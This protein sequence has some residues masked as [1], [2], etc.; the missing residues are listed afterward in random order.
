MLGKSGIKTYI[1]QRI[2]K[3]NGKGWSLSVEGADS[4]GKGA[5][6]IRGVKTILTMSS[7]YGICTDRHF[8]IGDMPPSARGC[9]PKGGG[10]TGAKCRSD[11]I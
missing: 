7:L 6:E 4:I 10:V 1:H 3:G 9:L 11:V 8:A 2:G 5:L